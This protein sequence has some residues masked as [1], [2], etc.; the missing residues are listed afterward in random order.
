M[1]D[2]ED[3]LT[4]IVAALREATEAARAAGTAAKA[5]HEGM[6][7]A[8]TDAA[9][10]RAEA[11]KCHDQLSEAVSGREKRVAALARD[12]KAMAPPVRKPERDRDREAR[13][14]WAAAGFIGGIILCAAFFF[15][16][17]ARSHAG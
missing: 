13:Y 2:E 16:A 7:Q 3:P 10:T 17:A 1:D 14:V 8:T 12:I 9:A 15:L 5:T 6:R 11:R 4:L